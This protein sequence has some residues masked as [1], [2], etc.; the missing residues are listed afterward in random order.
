MGHGIGALKDAAFYAVSVVIQ[1]GKVFDRQKNWKECGYDTCCL[2]APVTIAE[3]EYICQVVVKL[4]KDRNQFYLHE[5]ELK[6]ILPTEG[7]T[8]FYFGSTSGGAKG[9]LAQKAEE[10]NTIWE[11]CSK[12]VDENGEPLVVYHGTPTGGFTVFREEPY[13]TPHKWYAERYLNIRKPFDTRN[14]TEREIFQTEFYRKWGN[15]AP[16]SERVLPD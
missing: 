4:F 13:F 16:L 3:K 9:L 2:A 5:V 8:G 14:N 6:E 11:N 1:K 10:V 7:R 15:G 12:I